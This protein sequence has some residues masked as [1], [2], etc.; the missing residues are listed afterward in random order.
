MIHKPKT[1]TLAQCKKHQMNC[2]TVSA[3]AE[4]NKQGQGNSPREKIKLY[5]NNSPLDA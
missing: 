5:N 1:G 2:H 4:E 3:T